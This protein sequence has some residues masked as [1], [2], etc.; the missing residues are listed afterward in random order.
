MTRARAAVIL[1]ASV[2]LA[3]LVLASGCAKLVSFAD[4]LRAEPEPAAEPSY[5]VVPVSPEAEAGD[6]KSVV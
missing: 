5:Q 1:R 3:V 4:R 2:G 6:R